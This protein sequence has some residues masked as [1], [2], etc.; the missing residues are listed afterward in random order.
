MSRCSRQEAIKGWDQR[1]LADALIVVVGKGYLGCFLVWALSSMGVGRIL[2]IGNDQSTTERFVRWFLSDPCPFGDT[3]I[4]ELPYEPHYD[5]GLE[6]GISQAG[7]S[8]SICI[9][10]SEDDKYLNVLERVF[11]RKYS[12]LLFAGGES[13]GGWFDVKTGHTGAY[14]GVG[15][16]DNP[17]VAMAVAALLAD[18]ARARLCPLRSDIACEGGRL[19]WPAIS[20]VSPEKG[21]ARRGIAMLVGGGGIG[22]WAA[23]LLAI[24]GHDF[25]VADGDYVELSNLSRQG[26]FTTEDAAEHRNK[27]LAIKD[28]LQMLVP[29][30][31]VVSVP[32]RVDRSWLSRVAGRRPTALLSAVDNAESRLLLQDLGQQV[33]IPVLQAGT[34]AMCAD[35][36]SQVPGGP[37]L[38]EQMHGVLTTA[39]AKEATASGGRGRCGID[40]SW[41][42]PGMLA[43]A[44]LARRFGQ[45]VENEAQ[46]LPPIR[47]RQGDLPCEAWSKPDE[48]DTE[49]AC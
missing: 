24:C 42:V 40:P 49:F 34:D 1:K 38:N 14:A 27:A 4:I 23:T 7:G 19:N 45:V 41:V 15:V 35:C 5:V 21:D 44:M 8:P 18:E 12:A 46:S 20:D 32:E 6:W 30:A 39:A 10:T 2:W 22:V 16:R 9:H 3:S 36:F 25:I 13:G 31:R 37:T 17:V 33:G 28:R 47:W 29:T 11:V 48:C 43:G 26:L